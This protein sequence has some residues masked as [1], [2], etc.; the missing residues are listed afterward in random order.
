LAEIYFGE[1]KGSYGNP[2]GRTQLIAF[3]KGLR[4]TSLVYENFE[5]RLKAG[6]TCNSVRRGGE[7][8][9]LV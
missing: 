5:G 3:L 6:A 2:W 1:R 8:E 4:K 9:M 7:L